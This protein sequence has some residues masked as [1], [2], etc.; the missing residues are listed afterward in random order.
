MRLHRIHLRNY[1]GVIDR[2]VVFADSGIT[3]VEGP[4]EAGKTSLAEALNLLF[5]EP[6]S[7]AKSLVRAIKPTN[8]DEG[9]EVEVDLTTGP[10]RLH[11][12]KRWHKHPSTTLTIESPSREQLTGRSAHDRVRTILDE[13]LDWGLWKALR[14]EQDT[15]LTQASLGANP[16]LVAALDVASGGAVSGAAENLY[17]RIESEFLSYFTGAGR[18][19]REHKASTEELAR[20]QTALQQTQNAIDAVEADAEEHAAVL[21]EISTLKKRAQSHAD[22]LRQLEQQWNDAREH[23]RQLAELATMLERAQEKVD[24]AKRDLDVRNQLANDHTTRKDALAVRMAE[25]ENL[26]PAVA[27]AEKRASDA[28]VE[29]DRTQRAAQEAGEVARVAA[30]DVA[31][32]RDLFDLRLLKERQER[33]VAALEQLKEAEQTLAVCGVDDRGLQ[34][35]EEAYLQVELAKAVLSEKS[36]RLSIEALEETDVVVDGKPRTLIRGHSEDISITQPVQFVIANTLRIQVTPGMGEQE[37]IDILRRAETEFR[38]LC[39]KARVA[40]IRG[41]RERNT[42]RREATQSQKEAQKTL[43]AA[44]RDLTP[45]GLGQLV[46]SLAA[47][48]TDYQTKRPN[49]P[50]FAPDLRT[51]EDAASTAR[52]I[53]DAA[54]KEAKHAEMERLRLRDAA[55]AARNESVAR[56]TKFEAAQQEFERTEKLLSDARLEAS[57]DALQQRYKAALDSSDQAHAK[58]EGQTKFVAGLDPEGVQ[59]QLENAQ[60]VSDRFQADLRER[61]DRALRIGERISVAGGHGLQDAFDHAASALDAAQRRNE[62]NT[63]RAAAAQLLFETMRRHRDAAKRTYVAPFREHIERLGRIVFGPSFSVEIND[64]LQI[65]RR[66]L[67]GITVTFKDLSAGAREQLCIIAR[68]ACATLVSPDEGVPVIVDDALGHSD[69]QRLQRVGAVF[70]SAGSKAQ[71]IILTCM[72][73]RYRSIGSAHVVTLPTEH[74]VGEGASP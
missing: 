58:W 15:P 7:S 62:S 50:P 21:N 54:T 8:A 16:S 55:A 39:E 70:N 10:Y 19:T 2:E 61:E 46:V 4:N 13:T 45:E 22:V 5:D 38:S 32:Y 14:I 71:V 23:Q 24:A 64:D 41:A 47:G 31:Y 29:Y 3:I 28:A 33:A 57:D 27:A 40:D 63:R 65:A 42:E 44:L 34:K 25:G 69:P 66:T 12:W 9:A 51:A 68:L 52:K 36:A 49:L 53:A 48:T 18:P 6:D 72:P 60:K 11:Y 17:Q 59:T 67:N 56:A 73:D 37:R 1:R 43:A 74:L 30:E 26:V 35:L 20:T